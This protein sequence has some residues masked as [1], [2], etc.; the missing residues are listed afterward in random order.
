MIGSV[1]ANLLDRLASERTAHASVVVLRFAGLSGV[2]PQPPSGSWVSAS[3]ARP[4]STSSGRWPMR[5][6]AKH[7]VAVESAL[8][9]SRPRHAPSV[10]R[11]ASSA[12]RHATRACP[13]VNSRPSTPE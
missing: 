6:S 9:D 11:A 8:D 3:Q 4:A 5:D 13:G 7:A 2:S 1:A 10:P 12:A